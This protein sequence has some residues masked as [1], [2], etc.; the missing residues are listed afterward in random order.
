MASL[1]N[2]VKG[3]ESYSAIAGL[4]QGVDQDSTNPDLFQEYLDYLVKNKGLAKLDAGFMA[5]DK[6]FR[7]DPIRY[8]GDLR[9]HLAEDQKN[10]VE[11][12]G[13]VWNEVV[14]GISD[15]TLLDLALGL[16]GKGKEYLE[17]AAA[18]QSGNIEAGKKAYADRYK[19][20]ALQNYFMSMD[21]ETAKAYL[22]VYVKGEQDKFKKKNFVDIVKEINPKTKKEEEKEVVNYGKVRK[23]VVENIGAIKD[24][25]LKGPIYMAL[26]KTYYQDQKN[27]K[28]PAK[29]GAK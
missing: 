21:E 17:V 23:Y 16:P 25:K 26:A 5:Q 12:V 28:V 15:K 2:I 14:D 4:N 9:S 1:E 8:R 11:E 18:V 13:K 20:K 6:A 10:L 3:F 29:R 24:E 27:K 22:G 19:S 7:T